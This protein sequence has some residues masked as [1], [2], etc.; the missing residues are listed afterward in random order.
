MIRVMQKFSG[1]SKDI[2]RQ[3]I[4]T[5]IG[6]CKFVRAGIKFKSSLDLKIDF[7]ES[8]LFIQSH[9]KHSN[10]GITACYGHST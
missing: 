7:D 8:L 2:Q 4:M 10:D 9:E 6:N 3:A 1:A 5:L